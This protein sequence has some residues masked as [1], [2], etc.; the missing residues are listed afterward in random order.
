MNTD[1]NLNKG[2]SFNGKRIKRNHRVKRMFWLNPI[3]SLLVRLIAERSV[4]AKNRR[5]QNHQV[6][7]EEEPDRLLL[8]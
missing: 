8:L 7:T 6:T 4:A 2:G 1:R 3:L 5:K